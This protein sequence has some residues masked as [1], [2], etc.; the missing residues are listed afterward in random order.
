[1]KYLENFRWE[2]FRNNSGE[3]VPAY[4]IIPIT[5]MEMIGGD[6]KRPR[7]ICGKASTTFYRQWVITGPGAVPIGK[8]GKCTR[9]P[10]PIWAK[11]GS[12]TP[13]NGEGWGPA[14]GSFTLT[15]GSLGIFTTTGQVRSSD[16]ICLGVLVDVTTLLAK[17]TASITAGS[18]TSGTASTSFKIY[19]GS[20]GSESDSGFTTVPVAHNYLDTDID[21]DSWVVIRWINNGWT[22]QPLAAG[23]GG[24]NTV[25][26]CKTSAS[27]SKGSSVTCNI[28]TGSGGSESASGAS[29][30]NCYSKFAALGASKWCIVTVINGVNYITSGECT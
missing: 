8:P 28:Y 3:V 7:L 2:S 14:V 21:S 6:R 20:I 30:S 4:S 17:T 12:G 13:A 26:L 1:M 16:S 18:D 15:K 22:I 25:Y 24:G 11:H 27:V 29:L 5:G 10:G 9:G 23:S 19:T